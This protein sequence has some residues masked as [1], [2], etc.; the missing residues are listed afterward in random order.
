MAKHHL[1]EGTRWR[2][3]LFIN[4]TGAIMTAVVDS[5]SRHQVHTRRLGLIVVLVPIMVVFLVRLN[6]A[7]GAGA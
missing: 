5:S 7:Y 1:H 4:G 6:R 2:W 3:G